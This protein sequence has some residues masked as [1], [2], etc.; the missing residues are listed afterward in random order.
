MAASSSITSVGGM[1]I[2]TQVIPQ[3][4]NAVPLQSHVGTDPSDAPAPPAPAQKAEGS[5]ARRRGELSGLGA[6]QMVIA[7]LCVLFGSTG[8][9]HFLMPHLAFFGG[10]YL[11]ASG[12]LAAAA[13]KRTSV[14]LRRAC[15]WAN[16]VAVL[17]SL[18]GVAYLSWLLAVSRPAQ[19]VCGDPLDG[20]EELW[21]DCAHGLW[22][23]DGLVNGLRGL[24]L[25]LL[26]LQAAVSAAVRVLAAKTDP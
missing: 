6:V 2:V 14:T 5:S 3:D 12:G 21:R 9:S 22:M 25:V 15:V 16:T 24:F 19:N 1:L 4:G 20:E 18:G 23:L 8:I 13:E 7:V 17:L 11:L 26:V 10:A